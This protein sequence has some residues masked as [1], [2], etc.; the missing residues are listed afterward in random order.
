MSVS[1]VSSVSAYAFRKT[2]D[3]QEILITKKQPWDGS[4]MVAIWKNREMYDST[5]MKLLKHL[6]KSAKDNSFRNTSVVT[7]GYPDT[8]IGK[9]KMGRLV[10][11]SKGSLERVKK[12]YRHS[13]CAKLYFDIDMVNAQPVI[14]SQLAKRYDVDVKNLQYYTDNREEV[15]QK[16]VD[17][18]K[19][20]REDA[21]EWI[22]KCLFGAK[23]PE[24]KFLREELESLAS[25]LGTK[26]PVV[27]NLV[28]ELRDENKIGTFLAY[29]AQTEE[30]KCLLAMNRFFESVGRTVGVLAYDGCMVLRIEN[31]T[32]FPQ[33]LLSKCE[34][35]IFQSTNYKIKLAIKN[36]KQADEFA[37]GP[38]VFY[39]EEIDDKYM[40]QKFIN[41][42]GNK[43]KHDTKK[44]ILIY[45]D[46][47][48]RWYHD[49]KD[50]R[51]IIVASDLIE[52]VLDGVVNY[53]GFVQKQDLIIKQL[54]SL[55][56]PENFVETATIKSIGKLLFSN[57]IYDMVTKIFTESFDSTIYF[58]GSIPF[59]FPSRNPEIEAHVNKI[60]FEDPFLENEK[61]VGIYFKKLIARGIGG[62]YNDKT[63]VISVGSSDSGKSKL[64]SVLQ[65]IFATTCGT[66]NMNAFRYQKNSAQDEAKKNSWILQFYD[67]RCAF[68]SET[69]KLGIFD[70]NTLKTVV[71]GGDR[72]VVRSN[73]V[74]EF[75]VYNMATLFL[76][77]NDIPT[78]FPLDTAI[79][80]RIKLIEYKLTFVQNPTKHYE[81]QLIDID[82]L[83]CQQVYKDALMCVLFDSFEVTKPEPCSVSLSS[84]KEWVP[85][86]NSSI[87]EALENNGYSIDTSD[88]TIYVPFSELKQVLAGADVIKGMSD[89]AL[90]RELTK[91]GLESHQ[92]KISGKKTIVRK[93]IKHAD[94]QSADNDPQL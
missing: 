81:R 20:S 16:M 90:G 14:L 91:L 38:S 29:V 5:Q 47:T 37:I 79:C 64:F 27:F 4:A 57:G 94:N 68:G 67:K 33:D 39:K 12:I 71:S 49:D 23:I 89:T 65:D 82:S 8:P 60:F 19:I 51:H 85:N 18:Y 32:E 63:I 55:V 45:D 87:R 73:F 26:Y 44:G 48:G 31:E 76:A 34:E 66:F 6:I 13:L 9:L 77:C 75:T 93:Y 54:P 84:A 74:D 83:F 7:Y 2:K 69:S 92:V 35:Y 24:L 21:K 86:P 59:K 88:E 52:Y 30:C 10:S 50:I 80:N 53:S 36:M 78:F 72:I 22:I 61:E 62:Y 40:T 41:S 56:N 11:L 17:Y 70:S 42:M 28:D 46:K 25:I 1:Q 43:I 58:S 15:L 3:T